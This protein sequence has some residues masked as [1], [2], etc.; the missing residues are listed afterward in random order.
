MTT[1]EAANALTARWAA[2][3][4]D[5]GTVLSGTG[6]YVLLALL[7]PFAAGAAR[8][9]LPAG[10]PAPLD[11]PESPAT[12][13]ATAVWS[14]A[15]VPLREAFRAAVPEHRRGTLTGDPAVDQPV[16]DAWAAEQTGGLIPRFPAKADPDTLLM[17]A[18]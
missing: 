15:E 12:R 1:V 13:L 4:D 14:R 10:A 11:V 6:A 2:T 17:L 9:R 8:D 18:S 7:G 5:G 3:L 16:L